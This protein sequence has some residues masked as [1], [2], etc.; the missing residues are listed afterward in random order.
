MDRLLLL[1]Y[2]SQYLLPW[3]KLL[4]R[5]KIT[6]TFVIFS[7]SSGSIIYNKWRNSRLKKLRRKMIEFY[8]N[9]IYVWGSIS[10]Y[11]YFVSRRSCGTCM[12]KVRQ[13]V[14]SKAIGHKVGIW[15]CFSLDWSPHTGLEPKKMCSWLDRMDSIHI[16]SKL[17]WDEPLKPTHI[18]L[19]ISFFTTYLIHELQA[20]TSSV[21][22]CLSCLKSQIF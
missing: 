19:N 21:P 9:T 22:L 5:W 8:A 15:N 2:N 13:K 11:H 17:G 18:S 1:W 20:Y 10:N 4:I 16:S 3:Q 12:S 7:H 6:I 14:P